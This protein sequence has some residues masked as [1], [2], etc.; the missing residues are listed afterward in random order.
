MA[1]SKADRRQAKNDEKIARKARSNSFVRDR[2]KLLSQNVIEL[3]N[4]T[5]AYFEA[6]GTALEK[7]PS[8]SGPV[9]GTLGLKRL[10]KN[11]GEAGS[12]LADTNELMA[13]INKENIGGR[14]V[15]G[16]PGLRNKVFLDALA[17]ADRVS[18][19]IYSKKFGKGSRR[20]DFRVGERNISFRKEQQ[21]KRDA[22]VGQTASQRRNELAARRN[23]QLTP[24]SAR[25]LNE[26]SRSLFAERRRGVIY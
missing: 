17:I 5:K 14:H 6:G 3:Q 25:E 9:G 23:L 2:F 16:G 1:T 10:R 13:Q 12:I 19:G 18:G 15:R 7:V 22:A 11:Y 24:G 20:I 21:A 8:R 4:R 26:R